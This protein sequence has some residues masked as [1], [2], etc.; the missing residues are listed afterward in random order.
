MK[1][2]V[3]AHYVPPSCLDIMGRRSG[4][5]QRNLPDS[6]SD[7]DVRIGHMDERGVDVQLVSTPPWGGNISP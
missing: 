7:L 2:D 6:L 3:H 4:G 5:P 1:I